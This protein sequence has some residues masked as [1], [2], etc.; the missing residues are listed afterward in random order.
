MEFPEYWEILFIGQSDT[1]NFILQFGEY[2][3]LKFI[4]L[5][6]MKMKNAVAILR[7]SGSIFTKIGRLKESSIIFHQLDYNL[8]LITLLVYPSIDFQTDPITDTKYNNVNGHHPETKW[9]RNLRFEP[10]IAGDIKGCEGWW[11]LIT[12]GRFINLFHYLRVRVR[13]L[14][15]SGRYNCHK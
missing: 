11:Y 2:F 7:N 3:G 1:H 12:P 15:T 5:S 10:L 14:T 13:V 9:L 4:F 6:N 8:L